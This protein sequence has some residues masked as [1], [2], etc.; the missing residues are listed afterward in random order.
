MCV[1]LAT[2]FATDV[3]GRNAAVSQGGRTVAVERLP[4]R[5]SA[6]SRHLA[7]TPVIG[8]LLGRFLRKT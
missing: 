6:W 7:D 4:E 5:P 2:A 3:R 1:F 8:E